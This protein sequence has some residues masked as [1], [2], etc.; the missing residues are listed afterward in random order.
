M[1][2]FSVPVRHPQERTAPVSVVH[3][4]T[5]KKYAEGWD[6]IFAG[7]SKKTAAKK[8]AKKAAPKKAVKKAPAAKKA[9]VKKKTKK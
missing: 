4:G 9:T 5:S 2:R 3:A 8:S 7:S 1:V 6:S